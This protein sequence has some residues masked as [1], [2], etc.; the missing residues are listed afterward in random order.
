MPPA[1]AALP[2]VLAASTGG[3]IS[4]AIIYSAT[5]FALNKATEALTKKPK[6]G[7]G[8]G[9]EVSQIDTTADGRII[10]GSVRTGGI[11]VIPPLASG[12]NGEIL[13]QILAL[14]V[15]EVSSFGSV[16]LDDTEI[17]TGNIT[18]VSGGASDGLVTGSSKFSG[19]A[20]LRRYAGTSSQNVDYLLTTAF[21]SSFTST[22]RGRG[23]AYIASA[24]DWGKGK[25]YATGAP[26]VAVVVNGKVCYDPRLDG[27][28]GADP[29]NAAYAAHTSNPALIWADYKM[30]AVYGQNVLS[31]DIDWDTVVDAADVCDELVAI[32]TAT[33]QKRYTCNGV[34]STGMDT[35]DNEKTII[36]AMMGKLSF[37]GKWRI[38]AGA[39]R[40]PEFSIDYTDW[41]RIDTVQLVG[42][43]NESR[44]NGV[45]T[46]HVDPNK[47][48][49]RVE[50][51]RRYN[52][53]YKS[54]DAGERIWVEMEQPMCLTEYESQ[55]KG[56]FLLRQSRNGVKM[57]G[58]LPPKFM[59][60]RTWD[61]VSISFPE[62]GWTTKSFTVA[63][64]VPCP[65]GSVDV[66]LAEEQDTDWTDLLEAEYSAE[67][68]SSLPAT[69]QT[70]P[71]AP[72]PF[73]VNTLLGTLKFNFTEPVVKPVGMLYQ[74]IRSPGTLAVAG[75]YSV[76]WE[77]DA[78]QIELPADVRSLYWYH[79]RCMAS[80]YF[81]SFDPSTFGYG[82]APFI[83]PESV[84]GNRGFPD[85]ELNFASNSYWTLTD[86]AAAGGGV[87]SS[88]GFFTGSGFTNARGYI[89]CY[90]SSNNNGGGNAAFLGARRYDV[91][92]KTTS[93]AVPMISGQRG[94]AYLTVRG[95]GSSS[96]DGFDFVVYG[97]K[98]N[99]PGAYYGAGDTTF[100]TTDLTLTTIASGN[101]ITYVGTFTMVGS[102]YDAVAASVIWPPAYGGPTTFIDV[103]ALQLSVF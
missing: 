37:E 22:F 50:S 86:S 90:V 80:S 45:V 84:P 70:T 38:F 14:A 88:I 56:E 63:S 17:T 16:W 92:S 55:R 31:T 68:T 81:S 30:N 91:N 87:P 64:C 24:F 94:I 77:G 18:S 72:T 95:V 60:L 57:A 61:N 103:G 89:R 33:T 39:W 32:P 74:V 8:Q 59:K 34:L 7:A 79:G 85:G 21:P 35:G 2:A 6:S 49:Q 99:S 83:A 67:S 51:F 12:A 98:S 46:Y 1:L 58:K 96:T 10:Y 54:S 53:T 5:V 3:I 76:I 29:T 40:A 15:H 43:K 48:W 47:S 62:L 65:D 9:L 66:V 101:W 26:N 100:V 75:S 19:N 97:V 93:R 25:T 82:T 36:D 69:N 28:P 27:S 73:T 23:V 71:S 44:F 52:N 13:H 78:T 102:N 41:V 11:H 4:G 42:R 20:W